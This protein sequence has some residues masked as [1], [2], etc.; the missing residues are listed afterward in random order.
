LRI[1]ASG[2]LVES[3]FLEVPFSYPILTAMASNGYLV[4]VSTPTS[5]EA[6]GP[7]QM[8]LGKLGPSS[9]N[10]INLAC[11]GNAATLNIA[12]LAPGE[13][14]SL[15]GNG[16]G[17][18]TPVSAEFA[19]N[20]LPTTL[21]GTQVTLNRLPAPLLY[22]SDGQI[23]AIVP[24]G[25]AAGSPVNICA[26]AQG[27]S[28]NCI[29]LDV[30]NG[31][32]GIFQMPS[33]YAA[34]VNQDGTINSPQNPAAVGSVISL[35]TTGLGPLSPAPP[36]GSIVGFPLP[37]L[38]NSVK[39]WFWLHNGVVASQVQYAGPAPLEVAGLYQINVVV[40]PI[41]LLPTGVS[42]EVDLPDGS[43]IVTASLGIAI[44]IQ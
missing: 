31:A 8:E 16:L 27:K 14:I 19:N 23:N 2:G 18:A 10:E 30:A 9:A 1:D 36:D 6:V 20:L 35:Y 17:P 28:T 29:T 25:I 21:A 38:A 11:V 33:G 13:I 5:N 26:V 42:I 15:F 40:P 24:R 3:T 7:Y 22:A 4:I 43:A 32:P 34:A 44:A 37:A 41:G 12:A 39:A